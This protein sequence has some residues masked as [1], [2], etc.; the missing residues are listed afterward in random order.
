MDGGLACFIPCP[1]PAID[2]E[3]EEDL[4]G[5]ASDCPRCTG[6]CHTQCPNALLCESTHVSKCIM[7]CHGGICF[8]CSISV[9]CKLTLAAEPGSCCICMQDAAGILVNFPKCPQKHAFCVQCT[10]TMVFCPD[11]VAACPLCRHPCRRV[12]DQCYIIPLWD[13][14]TD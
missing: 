5:S 12:S 7:E 1:N 11:G 2:K 3:W 4:S 6:P 14:E 10:K 8:Y 13:I 9:G